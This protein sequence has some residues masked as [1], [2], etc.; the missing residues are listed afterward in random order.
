MTERPK[1]KLSK[2]KKAMVFKIYD[3]LAA[4]TIL[5]VSCTSFANFIFA[6]A[7]QIVAAAFF[8]IFA[9]AGVLVLKYPVLL[10]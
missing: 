10:H 2:R 4:I 6:Q 8:L 5:I 9:I 1:V 7:F 3:V